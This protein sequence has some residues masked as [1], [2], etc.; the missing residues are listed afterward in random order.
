MLS[1][2]ELVLVAVL[3]IP[4]NADVAKHLESGRVTTGA[5]TGSL[6][7]SEAGPPPAALI[8]QGCGITCIPMMA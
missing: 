4:V 2:L 5:V 7:P 1:D 8:P 6:A 3:V